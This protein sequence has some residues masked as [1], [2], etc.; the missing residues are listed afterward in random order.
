MSIAIKIEN[1]SKQYRLGL[2]STRTLSHDL[3][4]WWQT[5]ILGKEDPYLKIGETNIRESRGSSEYVWAL[6]DINL[7][8]EEGE[9]LGII[10]KNGAGKTTLLKI[11]SKVTAPTTGII[12]AKGRIASL[13]EVGTGFHQEM[14]GRENIFMNGS[15][16]GMTKA[17]INRKLDEIVDFAGIERYLDTPVKRYSSGMIVRL[18]FAVAAH[19]EPEILVVDEVLAVGDAEFQ[20][21]ALGKMQEVSTIEGRTVLFVSH[22]MASVSSLCT[23]GIILNNGSIERTGEVEEIISYYIQSNKEIKIK[24]LNNRYIGINSPLAYYTSIKIK[25]VNDEI[26]DSVKSGDEVT[27]SLGYKA[28]SP[29]LKLNFYIG[30]YNNTG[31]KLL[32]LGSIYSAHNTHIN[33]TNIE[34][35]AEC[36]FKKLPLPEGVYTLN[37]SLHYINERVDMV[38]DAFKLQVESGDFY[39]TGKIPPSSV[40]KFLIEQEWLIK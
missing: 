13:L 12:K 22:N 7:E 30:L 20:K 33:I 25:N 11:L 10:G 39:D 31:E 40:N 17:E 14:T 1:L 28:K 21:K 27:I 9:V 38:H 8:V 2:V 4:R 35:V 24:S 5:S 32:H 3:N 37:L 15:I 34:G 29:G 23:R 19:L 36:K 26:V 6:K 18:G 16:M